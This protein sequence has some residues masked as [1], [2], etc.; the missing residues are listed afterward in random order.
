MI[1]L[2]KVAQYRLY[3]YDVWGNSE[4]GWE[5][6]DVYR[7]SWYFS[8]GIEH[9]D[10]E[11][12]KLVEDIVGIELDMNNGISCETNIYFDDKEGKPIC[13]LRLRG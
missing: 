13:E 7:T 12:T 5:V 2:T 4:D 1:N 9:T 3:T 8:A 10:E 11:L 6:N